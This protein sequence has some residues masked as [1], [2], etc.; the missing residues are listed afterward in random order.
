MKKTTKVALGAMAGVVALGCIGAAV[1]LAVRRGADDTVVEAET[2]PV[3]LAELSNGEVDFADEKTFGLVQELYGQFEILPL[4]SFYAD[5]LLNEDIWDGNRER[6]RLE[7]T[8][9]QTEDWAQAKSWSGAAVRAKYREMFGEEI[10]LTEEKYGVATQSTQLVAAGMRFVI[11]HEET[12]EFRE[13]GPST[14]ATGRHIRRLERAEK[15]GDK[16]YLYERALTLKCQLSFESDE[17]GDSV[18]KEASCGVLTVAATCGTPE[19]GWSKSE[20]KM[21]DE[22]VLARAAERGL[23]LVRW[24]FERMEDGRY[25]YRGMNNVMGDG[26][27]L[28]VSVMEAEAEDYDKV[29]EENE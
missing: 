7:M 19:F 8:L 12:D 21:T 24:T 25:V 18:D 13:L 28:G 17:E 2:K 1:W 3:T 26:E 4:Q 20:E 6:G 9:N 5:E 23:G 15:D 10:E 22:A 27:V 14:V 16:V 29:K 11:Y